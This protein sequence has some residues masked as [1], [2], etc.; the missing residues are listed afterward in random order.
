MQLIHPAYFP[1]IALCSLLVK[2]DYIWEVCDNFQKQTYRNRCYIATDQGRKMLNIPIVHVG[3]E[4]GRQAYSDVRIDYST[5]WQKQHWKT[6]QTA[7]RTSPFFEFYEDVLAPFFLKSHKYL[8]DL[9]FASTTLICDCLEISFLENKSTVYKKQ[10]K[11]YGDFRF[12][13]NA[14]KTVPMPQE[15]YVQVFGD[16]H[17][18]LKNLSTL[19]LL[20]N[21]GPEALSYLKQIAVQPSNT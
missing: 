1:N 19:D 21:K 18:F 17:G 2:G 6:L 16:R 13:A 15:P 5:A 7:Y 4:Q 11:P 9:N 14:K 12:L 3:G 8:M 20:F 10:P